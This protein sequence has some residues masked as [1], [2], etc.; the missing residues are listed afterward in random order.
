MQASDYISLILVGFALLAGVA[1]VANL[2]MNWYFKLKFQFMARVILAASK[3]F[4]SIGG[5]AE[6]GARE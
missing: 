5:K 3:A 6:G 4:E 2:V 1:G